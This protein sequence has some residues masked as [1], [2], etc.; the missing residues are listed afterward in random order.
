MVGAAKSGTT[1]LYY[2]LRQHPQIFLPAS[3]EC[4]FF[5]FVGQEPPPDPVFSRIS[6]ITNLEQ[7]SDQ[8]EPATEDQRV[9]ECSTAYLHLWRQT[10]PNISSHYAGQDPPGI[11]IVVRNPVA[12]AYSHYMFDVQEGY[13]DESFEEVLARSQSGSISPYNNYLTYGQ[14]SEQVRAYQQNF[15]DVRVLV[16]DDLAADPSHVVRD[17]LEF[18]GVDSGT[19]IDTGFRA[20]VSGAPR[21]K[22]LAALVIDDNPIKRLIKPFLS[23][24]MRQ[25]LRTAV[26]SRSL[27]RQ[28]MSESA[29]SLLRDYY[30]EEVTALSDLLERDLSGWLDDR[31]VADQG[32]AS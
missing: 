27:R 21:H 13:V 15:P 26:L 7:Y 2:Y 30:K 1:S 23:D 3:K 18:L 5:A 11:V 4:W 22:R 20:N 31:T 24:A 14:Y 16:S 10:I 19:P 32:E 6:L 9:G 28:P 12:R 29:A 17:C 25:R 8:F